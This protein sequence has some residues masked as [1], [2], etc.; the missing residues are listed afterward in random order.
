MG[1]DMFSIEGK[2]Y[3]LLSLMVQLIALNILFSILSVPIFTI[4]VASLYLCHCVLNLVEDRKVYHNMKLNKRVWKQSSIA[5][6]VS[7]FSL[8]STY[9]LLRS[10]VNF[11]NLFIS[12]LLVSFKLISYLV[13]LSYELKTLHIFRVA[14]FYSL[15]YFYKTIIPVF[16]GLLVGIVLWSTFPMFI[17]LGLFSTYMYVFIK[18]N[19]RTLTKIFTQS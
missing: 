16:A 13:I 11:I 17:V 10:G 12:S 7:L 4:P 15:A 5:F 1:I 14:F 6:I 8:L 3:G 9:F 19:T 2:F 18:L